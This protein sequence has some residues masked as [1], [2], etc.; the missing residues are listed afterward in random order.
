[1]MIDWKWAV[2]AAVGILSF[3]VGGGVVRSWIMR[4]VRLSNIDDL[5]AVFLTRAEHDAFTRQYD[6]YCVRIMEDFIQPSRDF[7]RAILQL[8]TASADAAAEIRFLK[9]SSEKTNV[10][11]GMINDQLAELVEHSMQRRYTDPPVPPP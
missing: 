3:V 8:S 9:V 1:M 4:A 7:A 11:I 5:K 2:P 6:A 10:A